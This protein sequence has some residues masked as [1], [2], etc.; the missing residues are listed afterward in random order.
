MLRQGA[1]AFLR[2]CWEPLKVN[3]MD[4][5]VI[6]HYRIIRQLGEGG[7]GEVYL[8]Q[9]T[10]L[11]RNVAIKFL[12]PK[13]LQDEQAKQRFMRE[14][15]AAAT[16]D[17]ANI[18]LIHEEAEEDNHC[19]IVM[20]YVEGE[21]LCHK[22][23]E[24]PLTVRESVDIVIQVADALAEAHSHGVIHRDIKP[25]NVMIT[26]RGR[27]KVLDFG[28][29]KIVNEEQTALSEAETKDWLTDFQVIL[30]TVPYMSPEQLKNSPVD[31][32]SDLFSLGVVLYECL[33][34]QSPFSGT[35]W[36]EAAAQLIHIDPP[37]PSQFNLR[38]PLELDRA[39]LKALA[40]SPEARYQSAIEFIADLE[41]IRGMMQ[42][43]DPLLLQ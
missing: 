13:L 36:I 24:K 2:I 8:A 34:G 31:A 32:R 33:A 43:Q 25:R 6:S 18:C 39:N 42:Y 7:M 40:K 11:N 23:R 29:A 12:S 27:V 3:S 30:G 20:Q 28:L 17:H 37:P 21:T 9:D 4:S 16:L 22:I 41:K 19:F 15:Q 14:A 5:K 38:V 10:R 26:P 35:T 1:I